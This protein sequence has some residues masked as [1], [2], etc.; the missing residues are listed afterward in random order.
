MLTLPRQRFGVVDVRDVAEAHNTAMVDGA[1]WAALPNSRDLRRPTGSHFA[2]AVSANG[3]PRSSLG[4]RIPI[5]ANE[6]L[7]FVPEC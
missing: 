2:G 6:D 5:L 7:G 4:A 1:T 3:I